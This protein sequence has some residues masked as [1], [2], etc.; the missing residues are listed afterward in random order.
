MLCYQ[1][2]VDLDLWQAMVQMTPLSQHRQVSGDL[3]T[4]VTIDLQIIE[5]TLV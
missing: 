3:P 1:V 5:A 4:S 2:D